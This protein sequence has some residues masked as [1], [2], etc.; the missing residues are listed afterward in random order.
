MDI[1]MVNIVLD[2]VIIVFDI[3]LIVLIRKGW[4]K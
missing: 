4:K 2:F 1:E 3:A